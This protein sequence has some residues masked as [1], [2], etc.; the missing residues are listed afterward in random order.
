MLIRS[1][2]KLLLLK[3][4]ITEI[5]QWVH[6]Q[7]GQ[8]HAREQEAVDL[9]YYLWKAYKAAPDDEFVV[10]IKELKSQ[11]DD[12]RATYSEEDLM[13]RA[14]NKYEVRLRDEENTWGKPTDEQEKIV[15]ITAEI[16]SLKK[17][18]RGA[19]DMSNK[20]VT[21]DKKPA[22]K[23]S[24]EQKK[25]KETTKKKSQDNWAWKNKPPMEEESKEDNAFVK[26]FEGKKYF[27][28]TNHNNGAGMWTLDHPKDCEAGKAP[29]CTSAKAHIAS[30][31]TV[32]SDSD[33]E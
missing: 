32:D 4:N 8:L 29:T 30:F 12:S 27:W 9:L 23:K 7:M 26:S 31:D 15:A 19:A 3:G 1:K 10:Y 5:N 16:N 14:E 2:R 25:T 21:K 33:M 24:M 13:V 17:D 6:K 22:T 28:S 18:Q 20:T 11:A